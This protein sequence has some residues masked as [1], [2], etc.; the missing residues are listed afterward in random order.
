MK[1]VGQRPR[2]GSIRVIDA[3]VPAIRPGWL[4]VAN[5]CSLISAG[6]ERGR[7][8]LGEKNLIQKARARPDLVRKVIDRARV[9]GVRAAVDS[10]RERLEAAVPLGYSSA[11][12]VTKVGAG[13]EGI[14]PGDHVAC[15][16]GGLA[17]HAEM[18]AVPRNLVAKIPAD[19][20]FERA[21]YATVGAVA[22]HGIRRAEAQVGERIGVVGLGLVGQLAVRILAASGCR[23]IGIDL[24]TAAV[25]LAASGG[26]LSFDREHVGLEQAVGKATGSLGLDAVLVCAATQSSDP[27]ALAARLARDRARIVIVGDVPIKADRA[28][29]Y[30]KELELRLSRSYGPGRY[31]REYEERGRDLP[32]GYVRWTEQR[33]MEAFLDLVAEGKVDPSQLTTH[34]FPVEQAAKAYA[35]LA[36]DDEARP[37]GILLDYSYEATPPT[38]RA[39]TARPRGNGGRIG[40]VGAGSFARAILLPALQEAGAELAAVSTEKGLTAADVATRFGFERTAASSEEIFEDESIHAVVVA[41]RHASHAELVVSALLAGKAVFV[42]KP[43]ALDQAELGEIERALRPDSL[44]MVGFNRRFAPLTLRLRAELAHTSAATMLARVNAGPVPEDHWTI[45]PAEGGGRLLGEGCHFVDL[46]SHLAGTPPRSVHAFAVPHPERPLECSDEVVATIRFGTSAVGTLIYSG[47]GDPRMPKE[48]VEA[49]GG[50]LAAVLDDFRRLEL[51]RAGK[52]EIVKSRQDKGHKAQ[53]AL[54][55]KA[56]RGEAEPP[57]VDSYLDST[58]ATIALVESLRNG[59]PVELPR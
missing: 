40:V 44:L 59:E 21:A 16:G 3:P 42:E 52:S 11:G 22:L 32:P 18:V 47:S 35:T 2:D 53:M 39:P 48:R 9:E 5:R 41:T 51:H 1:Q 14:G 57:P 15:G 50:G 36:D 49:F 7:V 23:P 58:R 45:D 29:F 26:I 10:A 31:D 43:L 20:P 55:V 19:V 33:N 24:D 6:T 38:P 25:A 8:E 30:E 27:V 46:L 12:I 37:F 56:A 17:N 34:R 28:L 13:V 4:L 54:F